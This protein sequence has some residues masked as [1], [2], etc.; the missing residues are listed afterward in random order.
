MKS[1]IG[2]TILLLAFL[3]LQGCYSKHM[4]AFIGRDIRYVVVSDGQ[5]ENAMDMPDGQ[6]AFQFRVGGG[7]VAVPTRTTTNGDIQLVG[8]S[9]YYSQQKLETAGGIVRL[10]GCLVTYF[11]RWD[12][13]QKGWIVTSISYPKQL[14]C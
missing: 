13:A 8:N 11:A 12:A 3:G 6:R 4:K 10:P 2:K 9:I 5:S 7:A 14:V 1:R